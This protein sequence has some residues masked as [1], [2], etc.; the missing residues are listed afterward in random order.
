M[1]LVRRKKRLIDSARQFPGSESR[2]GC[3]LLGGIVG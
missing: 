1:N 2:N 3:Q